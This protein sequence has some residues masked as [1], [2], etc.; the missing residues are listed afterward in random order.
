MFKSLTRPLGLR[1]FKHAAR[2][3]ISPK[4]SATKVAETYQATLKELKEQLLDDSTVRTDINVSRLMGAIDDIGAVLLSLM[5][6]L[7]LILNKHL[8]YTFTS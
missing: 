5:Q 6:E 3:L 7:V 2:D 1:A 4:Q 8:R